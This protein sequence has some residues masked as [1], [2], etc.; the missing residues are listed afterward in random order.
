MELGSKTVESP[1]SAEDKEGGLPDGGGKEGGGIGWRGAEAEGRKAEGE[2]SKYVRAYSGV[3][4]A[5]GM[6]VPEAPWA[7]GIGVG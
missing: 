3:E 4:R 7:E 6:G 5:E 1:R 2:E